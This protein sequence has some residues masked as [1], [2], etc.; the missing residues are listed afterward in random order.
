VTRHDKPWTEPGQGPQGTRVN[1]RWP[2]AVQGRV[3][4]TVRVDNPT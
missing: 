2:V 1:L 3:N 4:V